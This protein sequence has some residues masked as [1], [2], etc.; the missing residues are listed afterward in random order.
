MAS[1]FLVVNYS[2]CCLALIVL[3]LREPDLPRPYRASL[4]PWSV[5]VVIAGG[6]TFLVV[7]LFGDSF[8]GLAALGLLAVG[9]IGRAALMRGTTPP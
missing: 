3:R 9:L 7:M 8:N 5:L 1:F 2:L 4:Y 6:I